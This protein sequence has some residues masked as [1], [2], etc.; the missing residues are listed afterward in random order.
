[1]VGMSAA[2]RRKPRLSFQ[3]EP[4]DQEALEALVRLIPGADEIPRS[5][6]YVALIRLGIPTLVKDPSV[7]RVLTAPIPSVPAPKKQRKR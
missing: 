1:M 7:A 3:I 4:L 5:K 2:K 6:L